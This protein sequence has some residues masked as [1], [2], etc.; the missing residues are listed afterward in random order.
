MTRQSLLLAVVFP[1]VLTCRGLSQVAQRFLLSLDKAVAEYQAGRT[2]EAHRLLSQVIE[3]TPEDQRVFLDEHLRDRH[4]LGQTAVELTAVA[5]VETVLAG[6]GAK[7][8]RVGAAE[9]PT[10]LLLL[11]SRIDA[12]QALLDRELAVGYPAVLPDAVIDE[13]LPA[14]SD[15]LGQTE[16]LERLLQYLEQFVARLGAAEQDHLQ[17]RMLEIAERNHANERKRLKEKVAR[18]SGRTVEFALAGLEKSVAVLGDDHV[19]FGERFAAAV[20]GHMCLG[21]VR[22]HWA[23]YKQWKAG[24]PTGLD[25]DVEQRWRAQEALFGKLA[26]ALLTKVYHYGEGTRWWLRGRYGQAPFGNGM[27]KTTTSGLRSH[28]QLQSL[29]AFPLYMPQPFPKLEDPVGRAGVFPIPRRHLE[30]WRYESLSGLRGRNLVLS[31]APPMI[32]PVLGGRG[33]KTNQQRGRVV[34]ENA[35]DELEAGRLV[36]YLE[37][38]LALHH[39]ERLLELTSPAE[40]QTMDELIGRD[41]RF[42]VHSNL[43]RRYNSLEPTSTLSLAAPVPDPR[44]NGPNERI[45]LAWVMAL[46]RVEIGAMRAGM[47]GEISSSQRRMTSPRHLAASADGKGPFDAFP[48]TNF[49]RDAFLEIMLDGV[50]QHY[51]ESRTEY[52]L[53]LRPDEQGARGNLLRPELAILFQLERKL[54]VAIEMAA[55]FRQAATGLTPAQQTELA[56]WQS[57]LDGQ[58]EIVQLR[59][60]RRAAEPAR[61]AIAR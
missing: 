24:S 14:F 8:G 21:V 16:S 9:L 48:P 59:L 10:A 61:T 1:L 30:W 45:G 35:A 26:G 27:V 33:S 15:L 25:P 39:F 36:G 57:W 56:R 7:L 50:R 43:S 3:S 41:P 49:D 46:A 11:G 20:R 40:R 5:R 4:G 19:A 42:V 60:G 44:A 18:L 53:E 58:F 29:Q 2:L 32:N 55:A 17:G 34:E 51:Y 6:Q 37:Y 13:K 23:G 52:R 28:Q 22:T 31:P 12:L 47:L 54:D 38:K